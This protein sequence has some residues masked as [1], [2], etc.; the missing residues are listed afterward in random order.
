MTFIK[1]LG[2]LS[3][4]Q[5][6]GATLYD[7]DV[8]TIN[9]LS[10]GLYETWECNRSSA[11]NEEVFWLSHLLPYGLPGARIFTFR[12]PSR[13][14]SNHSGAGVNDSARSLLQTLRQLSEGS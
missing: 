13:W 5:D 11:H 14:S 9:S 4:V 7:V 2:I 6:G 12:Y 10:G 3:P 1:S 8:V